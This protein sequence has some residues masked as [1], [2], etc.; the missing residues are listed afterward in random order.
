MNLACAVGESTLP[1][2]SALIEALTVEL[3]D[4]AMK[5]QMVVRRPACLRDDGTEED[6][7]V[8][9]WDPTSPAQTPTRVAAGRTRLAEFQLLQQLGPRVRR[10]TIPPWC[11]CPA[12]AHTGPAV[13][14]TA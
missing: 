4:P 3:S 6:K 2:C 14:E 1:P 8:R 12:Q 13:E 5:G 7:P 9:L 11:R 10:G